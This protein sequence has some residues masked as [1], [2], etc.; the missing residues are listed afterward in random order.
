MQK[1]TVTVKKEVEVKRLR[2][3]AGVRY[4]NSFIINGIEAQDDGEGVPCKDGD[5]WKPIIDLNSGHILN[6]EVGITA[7]VYAKVCDDGNYYLIDENNEIVA[8]IEQDYVPKILCPKENGYGDYIIMDIN[9]YG[10]ISDFK[11][12]LKDFENI[13]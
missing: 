12:I 1:L 6:W 5:R 11:P 7:E 3:D 8:K 4:W 9:K 13:K 2:V 10:F